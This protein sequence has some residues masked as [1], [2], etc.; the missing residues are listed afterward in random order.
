MLRI[1]LNSQC[2]EQALKPRL[3][4]LVAGECVCFR[5]NVSNFRDQATAVEI[6]RIC[7]NP[8]FQTVW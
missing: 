6:R 4:S 3:C 8:R 5:G 2:P 7:A 1:D